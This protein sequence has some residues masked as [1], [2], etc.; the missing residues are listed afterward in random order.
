[1][2]VECLLLERT[3]QRLGFDLVETHHREYLF[4]VQGRVVARTR[5]SR[6][7]SYRTLDDSIVAE[8]AKQLKVDRRFLLDLVAGKRSRDEYLDRLREQGIVE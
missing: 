1:M 3:L 6:G 5:I 7:S 8:V 4:R 2:P